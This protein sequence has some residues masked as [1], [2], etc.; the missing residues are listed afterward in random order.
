[1]RPAKKGNKNM[2]IYVEIL[3]YFAGVC[4]AICFMPQTIKTIK[5]K[6]VKALSFFSYLLY[7]LGILS[8]IV[9]G[10]FLGSAPMVIFNAISIV[11]ASTVLF[12]IIKYKTK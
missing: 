6:D 10:Y 12:M 4:T 9:Y 8:W 2:N 3:G 1:M 7:N 5:T 11:F